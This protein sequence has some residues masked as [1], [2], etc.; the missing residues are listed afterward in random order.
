[1]EG[2][3]LAW[4]KE[5]SKALGRRGPRELIFVSGTP[6][7][8]GHLLPKARRHYLLHRGRV[9]ARHG[10]LEQAVVEASA[11]AINLS[12]TASTPPHP[13]VV[14]EAVETVTTVH[15][16]RSAG[17]GMRWEM[18]WPFALGVDGGR[19]RGGEIKQVEDLEMVE[20]GVKSGMVCHGMVDN[21]MLDV[22]CWITV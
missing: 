11:S 3:K 12:H 14:V 17:R 15:L 1:M 21:R 16:Q 13:A 6:P 22:G 19:T 2:G 5:G 8:D 10:Y 20:H 4:H 9:P 7:A 18:G